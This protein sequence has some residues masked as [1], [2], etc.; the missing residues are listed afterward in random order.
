MDNYELEPLQMQLNETWGI[1]ETISNSKAFGYRFYPDKVKGEGFFIAAFRNKKEV[2][3]KKKYKEATLEKPSKQELV[4]TEKMIPSNPNNFHFKHNDGIRIF[5]ANWQKQLQVL[6]NYLYI[7]K[8]G[9]EIGAVKG[10]DLIPSHELAVSN[11]SLQNVTFFNLNKTQALQYLSKKEVIIDTHFEGW[12]LLKYEDLALGWVKLLK[13]R[14]N[15]YYPM[16][17]RILNTNFEDEKN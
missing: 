10:K 13:N 1:V 15:N 2:L 9:I 11:I 14:M 4:V 17:W 12:A 3:G 8:A 16:E 5:P 7:K 6:A